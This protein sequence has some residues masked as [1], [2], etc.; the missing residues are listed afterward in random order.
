V[1]HL[2]FGIDLAD[3]GAEEAR[4]DGLGVRG[5]AGGACLSPLALTLC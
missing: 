5:H 2:A 3:Y 1:D 4:L